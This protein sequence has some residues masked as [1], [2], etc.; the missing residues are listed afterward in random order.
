[1]SSDSP[2]GWEGLLEECS[3]SSQ[4]EKDL[5]EDLTDSNVSSERIWWASDLKRYSREKGLE[6]PV[7][8]KITL[9]SCCTGAFAEAA[10]LKELG[11]P[12]TCMSTSEPN[13]HFRAFSMANHE[14]EHWYETMEQQVGLGTCTVHPHN[15]SGC[16]SAVDTPHYLVLGTPCNPFSRQSTKRFQTGGVKDHALYQHTF[17]DVFQVLDN[18]HPPTV[19]M[20]QSSGFDL[21]YSTE[22]PTTPLSK[23]VQ[24]FEEYKFECGFKYHI[25]VHHL[26]MN[27]WLKVNRSRITCNFST[28]RMQI[29]DAHLATRECSV[30]SS[31]AVSI[32]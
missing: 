5:I 27:K 32:G 15:F 21:P 28:I 25:V 14:A 8:K 30:N 29:C 22:D 11:I 26:D 2:P 17:T 6:E 12:F 16:H 31:P 7:K 10:V 24:D 23:F 18:F 20:E 4:H 13:A 19:T 1:M 9:M 3:S